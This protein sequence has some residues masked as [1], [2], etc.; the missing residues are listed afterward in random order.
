MKIQLTHKRG[1]LFR[2]GKSGTD[3]SRFK[4]K[5][6]KLKQRTETPRCKVKLIKGGMDGGAKEGST[7]NLQ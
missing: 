2:P 1:I 6:L 5:S 4:L 3:L 7:G